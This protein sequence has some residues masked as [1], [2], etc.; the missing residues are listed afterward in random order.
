MISKTLVRELEQEAVTTKRLLEQLPED[1]LTW[2][3]HEKSM[4]LGQLALHIANIPG[5]VSSML[6]SDGMDAKKATFVNPQPNSKAEILTT[7][8][9]AIETAKQVLNAWDDAAASTPWRL[10]KGD[11]EVFTLPRAAVARTIMMNHWYH[12]RGQ[13]TV[14]LRLLNVLLPVTY[15]RSADTNPFG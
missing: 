6:N 3:P 2:T 15:G 7:L 8:D 12:H 4:T 9:S 13:L 1:K 5:R 10:S 11:E 14:Y